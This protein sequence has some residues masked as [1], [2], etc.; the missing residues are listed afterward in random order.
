MNSFAYP[1]DPSLYELSEV[2]RD[3]LHVAVSRDDGELRRR[4]YEVQKESAFYFMSTATLM[5]RY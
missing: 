5:Y 2:A 3:F 4:I 1:L